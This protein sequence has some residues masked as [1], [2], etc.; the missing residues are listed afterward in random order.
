MLE[1]LL[2][3]ATPT[4]EVAAASH[5]AQLC[6]A[7]CD[8]GRSYLLQARA[9]LAATGGGDNSGSWAGEGGLWGALWH[10][11]P[12]AMAAAEAA[13]RGAVQADTASP[14]AWLGLGLASRQPSQA[15][16]ALVTAVMAGGGG[17]ALCNLGMLYLLQGEFVI[18]RRTFVQAQHTDPANAAMW[19]GVGHLAAQLAYAAR[20]STTGATLPAGLAALLASATG[21]GD[22]AG[23]AALRSMT[24][25]LSGTDLAQGPEATLPAGLLAG[26]LVGTR[27]LPGQGA[28]QGGAAVWTGDVHAAA[29]GG[30]P[31]QSLLSMAAEAQP[32][33]VPALLGL[34][35]LAHTRAVAA[36]EVGPPTGA[37]RHAT[38]SL[39]WALAAVARQGAVAGVA[40]GPSTP[41]LTPDTAQLWV[42]ACATLSRAAT[43]L[44]AVW[45]P[46][47][48]A[49]PALA[50]VLPLLQR[51][52]AWL[53][54]SG[55]GT[56]AA[57]L[58]S[59]PGTLLAAAL[60]VPGDLACLATEVQGSQLAGRLTPPGVWL[61][62]GA[63]LAA[64]PQQ[65]PEA[66][67][68]TVHSASLQACLPL[69][70]LMAR[71][72][73]AAGDAAA[74]LATLQDATRSTPD[75]H[76]PWRMGVAQGAFLGDTD[77]VGSVSPHLATVTHAARDAGSSLPT[78]TN[79]P[80]AALRQALLAA[81]YASE[82]VARVVQGGEDTDSAADLSASVSAALRES[83]MWHPVSGGADA[84]PA[85]DAP[86]TLRLAKAWLR[87]AAASLRA[88]FGTEDP[89]AYAK[90]ARG[91]VVA[92]LSLACALLQAG[93][94][95][96]AGAKT[97]PAPGEVFAGDAPT[98]LSAVCGAGHAGRGVAGAVKAQ[99]LALLASAP[100]AQA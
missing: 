58:A 57:C 95:D 93:P 20:T 9:A 61:V 7:W 6:V 21:G 75:A 87:V 52:L 43:L 38:T 28:V 82:E 86:T 99:A 15:Q 14:A 60:K 27:L 70:L 10:V 32:A 91:A 22:V 4:D 11:A 76:M 17:V 89:A 26:A 97:A 67:A 80:Q 41:A 88:Q 94:S 45:A 8:L 24:A 44:R 16:H 96:L 30:L 25:F 81:A 79:A 68:H 29:G 46:A 92:A 85:A 39:K 13:Y 90:L 18:A 40:T 77:L 47:L 55:A 31:P 34:A 48:P 74:A 1:Q 73:L 33:S 5:Q 66:L 51:C 3:A 71:L 64:P 100:V 78:T 50:A 56:L 65:G 69:L 53:G 49:P 42:V 36:W 54:S 98:V 37:L 35:A 63:A 2:V 62:A 12:S 59:V 84:P 23:E 83:S 72:Q 19:V